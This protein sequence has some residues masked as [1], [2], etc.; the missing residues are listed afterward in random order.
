L[1][2][3]LFKKKCLGNFPRAAP[4]PEDLRTGTLEHPKSPEDNAPCKDP[5]RLFS[6]LLDAPLQDGPRSRSHLGWLWS[7]D[8]VVEQLMTVSQLASMSSSTSVAGLPCP[9]PEGTEGRPDGILSTR[10]W[11]LTYPTIREDQAFFFFFCQSFFVHAKSHSW[12]CFWK[13]DLA[14]LNLRVEQ[15][16]LQ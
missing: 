2:Q 9:C 16:S 3:Q 5:Q 14:A 15:E 7:F 4:W 8:W 13:F 10:T 6:F 1:A 12:L 11:H